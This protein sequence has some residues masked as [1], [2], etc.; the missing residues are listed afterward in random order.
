MTPAGAPHFRIEEIAYPPIRRERLLDRRIDRPRAARAPGMGAGDRYGFDVVGWAIGNHSPLAEVELLHRGVL[1][2][3]APV[4]TRPDIAAGHPDALHAARSGIRLGA[5]VV[6]LPHRFRIV[7]RAVLEDDTRAPVAAISG[8]RE[9][10]PASPGP[11]PGP[12]LLTMIGRSGSTALSNLLC[13]HPDIAGFRTWD[14]ETRVVSYWADVLRGL[15]RPHSY[16]RQLDAGGSMLGNWWLGQQTAHPGASDDPRAMQA[17]GEAGV[18]ALAA[19]CSRQIGLV[20]GKLAEAAGKPGARHFVE[21]TEPARS[22]STAEIVEEIDPRTRELLLVR[23]P[24]DM[25]CSM[26]AY[27]RKK[28]FR[29]FGPSADASLEDTIRWL[30]SGTA[31]LV[32]YMERRGRRAHLVRYEEL[33]ARPRETL[34]GV[35]EHIGADSSPAIVDMML[36]RLEGEAGRRADHATTDSVTSSVGRWRGEM[37]EPQQALAEELF[38]PHLEKL[39]YT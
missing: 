30:S 5:S 24:R 18:E 38:R 32:D 28:G 13:H 4:H 11:G 1:L 23:D 16:E 17:I 27:S 39:G 37:N 7:V 6:D 9:P 2:D 33:A 8:V 12:V 26:R 20:A 36:E 35:L 25:A 10:L 29:G 19:F 15:A 3:R 21:K 22:R 34:A 14:T 31:G